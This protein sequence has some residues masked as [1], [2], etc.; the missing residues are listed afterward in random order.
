MT[1]PGGFEKKPF[2]PLNA[3]KGVAIGLGNIVPGVSGGT[4]AVI[5]GIYDELVD[6][7]GN[8]FSGEGGWKKNLAFLAPVIAGALLGNVALARVIGRLLAEAPGPANFGFI[9]LILGSAP[10]LLKRSGIRSFRPRYLLLFAAGLPLVLWTGLAPS[11]AV[12]PPVTDLTLPAAGAVFA[13]ALV[14]GVA[15]ALPGV[16]GGFLLLLL[17]MYSTLQHGFGT[18]NIPLILLFTGGTIAGVCLVSKAAAALLKRFHAGAYA[19]IIGLVAGSAVTI[20]PGFS[21]GRMVWADLGA[22]FIGFGLSLSLG[23][24]T[25]ERL[26]RPGRNN[27]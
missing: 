13:A 9:G 21:P 16:S 3:L 18:L 7:F 25:G 23:T 10:Y 26:L 8:F 27:L 22:F 11:P 17:G 24:G 12:S 19:L 20:Y 2:S 15:T 6:A 4:V 5:T 14:S 1:A